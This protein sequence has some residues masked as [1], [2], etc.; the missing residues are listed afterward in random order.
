LQVFESFGHFQDGHTFVEGEEHSGHTSSSRN[1]E[2][3][4]EVHNFVR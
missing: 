2:I 1:V 4:V 3:I